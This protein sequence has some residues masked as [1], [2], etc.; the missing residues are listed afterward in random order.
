LPQVPHAFAFLIIWQEFGIGIVGED[1][2]T[3]IPYKVSLE[4]DTLITARTGSSAQILAT[5]PAR[6]SRQTSLSRSH[7][8]SGPVIRVP[9]DNELK[10]TVELSDMLPALHYRTDFTPGSSWA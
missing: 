1:S 2:K 9:N 7:L 10:S 3:I 8:L 5:I 6:P 4:Q